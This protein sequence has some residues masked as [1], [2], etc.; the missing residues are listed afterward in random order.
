MKDYLNNMQEILGDYD[1]N[2]E[3]VLVQH[4]PECPPEDTDVFQQLFV[5]KHIDNQIQ[6]D[7]SMKKR[8][9]EVIEELVRD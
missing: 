8:E 3:H 5:K 2:E 9:D 7:E 1:I 6:F 4:G